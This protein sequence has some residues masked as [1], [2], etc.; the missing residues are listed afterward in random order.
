MS[1]KDKVTEAVKQAMRSGEKERLATLRYISASLKDF[2]VNNRGKTLTDADAIAIL[3]KSVKSRRDSIAQFESGGRVDLVAK[4][5]AEIAILEEFLPAEMGE[6]EVAA[7]VEA[8][9]AET[10]A[11]SP[12]QVGLVMKAAIAKVAGRADGSVI[13]R[14]VRERLAALAPKA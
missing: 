5:N 3:R 14:L 13:N 4:E 1:I 2:E 8:A 12:Q 11:A 7:L 6:A 9:I 10:G